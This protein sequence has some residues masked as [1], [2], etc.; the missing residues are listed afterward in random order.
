MFSF[1]LLLLY[2]NENGRNLGA[3]DKEQ[4]YDQILCDESTFHLSFFLSV[5][6]SLSFSHVFLYVFSYAW[7]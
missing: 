6:L 4:M 3:L 2:F 7:V 5:F 1:S